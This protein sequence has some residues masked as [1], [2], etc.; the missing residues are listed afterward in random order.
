MRG[1]AERLELK[2]TELEIYSLYFSFPL[3]FS[4]TPLPSSRAKHRLQFIPTAGPGLKRLSPKLPKQPCLGQAHLQGPPQ[5]VVGS[6]NTQPRILPPSRVALG[7]FPPEE[8]ES[9]RVTGQVSDVLGGP[10]LVQRVWP[11]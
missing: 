4:L 6:Y 5:K 3:W 8:A 10:R 7:L 2:T 11:L 9:F 1:K